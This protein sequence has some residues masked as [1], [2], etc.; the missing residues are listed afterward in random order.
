MFFVISH[1]PSFFINYFELKQKC[2][3]FAKGKRESGEFRVWHE[4]NVFYVGAN[5]C[6]SPYSHRNLCSRVI[7]YSLRA[8]TGVCPYKNL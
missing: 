6:V 5:P 3:T 8:N 7:F 4:F 1:F 2:Y